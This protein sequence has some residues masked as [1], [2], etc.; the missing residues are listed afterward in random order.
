MKVV[1][2]G[3]G[4]AGLAVSWRL[5]RAGIEACLLE[6]HASPGM[7]AHGVVIETARGHETIDV[8][9]RVF[10]DDYY[11]N[12]LALYDDLGLGRERID[13]SA[14]FAGPP[15]DGAP[16]DWAIRYR[17]AEVAG[18]VVPYLLPGGSLELG[19]TM[20]MLRFYW[21]APRYLRRP[22]RERDLTTGQFLDRHGYGSD[23]VDRFLL[24][25]YAAICTTTTARVRDI[26]AE[27]VIDYM[28]R[29]GCFAQA[30]RAA[31]GTRAV[32]DRLTAEIPDV[33][34][35]VRVRQVRREP[36]GTPL[37][38]LEGQDALRADHVVFATQANQAR[39]LLSPLSAEEDD[40][41]GAFA[42]ERSE[43]VT[44]RDDSLVP[45]LPFRSAV[46]FEIA[47]EAPAP[48][49]TMWMNRIQ[50][51][52][53]EEPDVF[54]TWNP[55]R[56]PAQ[57]L[58]LG[59]A[60][61][62]RPVADARSQGALARLD[63]LHDDPARRVWFCGSYARAGIPLLESAVASTARVVDELGRRASS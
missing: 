36:D 32:V 16:G 21:T 27:V 38:E 51:S 53:A 23:F 2:I 8:P 1:V 33:R 6:R 20:D 29:G 63:A 57:E 46:N 56:E 35:G 60:V 43:V 37:V 19:L 18:W 24:P 48:A 4:L 25:A 26:P 31:G 28:T 40:V 15:S 55:L 12:L 47:P 58:E 17:T 39:R 62:E 41:L 22:P 54:Q 61:F 7:G 10:H 50:P 44:H 11:P 34:C 42:Y 9:L 5:E 14:T 30:G 13:Y 45:R 3:G 49:A 59:R 52:L